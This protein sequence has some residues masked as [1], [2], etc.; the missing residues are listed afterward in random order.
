ELSYSGKP[1]IWEGSFNRTELF[2]TAEKITWGGKTLLNG[3]DGKFSLPTEDLQA[4]I[5][6]AYQGSILSQLRENQLPKELVAFKTFFN[7][8]NAL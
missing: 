5:T 3:A 8:L 2:C 6:F 1:V 4:P 7:E